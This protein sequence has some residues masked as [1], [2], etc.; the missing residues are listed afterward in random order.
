[1][2]M[3]TINS[4]AI[5]T[6][7]L[8]VF[9]SLAAAQGTTADGVMQIFEAGRGGT[10]GPILRE[11]LVFCPTTFAGGFSV[12]CFASAG[13]VR[14]VV[15]ND[16][17]TTENV[18]PFYIVGNSGD[19]VNPW[20]SY[21]SIAEITCRLPNGVIN[22]VQVI[23]SCDLI[24]PSPMAD[25]A[26][27]ATTPEP[28]S[29]P[30]MVPNPFPT[31]PSRPM[32][33]VTPKPLTEPLILP[34]L[35]APTPTPVVDF[36]LAAVP[37]PVNVAA[38]PITVP[39]VS[40]APAQ[41]DAP[42][43]DRANCVIIKATDYI[44]PMTEGWVKEKDCV[45]FRKN[46]ASSMEADAGT[47]I[48]SYLFVSPST[49]KFAVTLD[50]TTSG[51]AHNSVYLQIAGGFELWR[52]MQMTTASGFVKAFSDTAG[53][54]IAAYSVD[55]APHTFVTAVPLRSGN[56]NIIVVGARSTRV[57]V[58]RVIMW[59]CEGTNCDA[60]SAEWKKMRNTCSS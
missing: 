45:T 49:S 6:T 12:K 26:M 3:A 34:M 39:I 28:V 32:A 47:S 25:M 13:P 42:V 33:T 35:S 50:T 22:T 1:M 10:A 2:N 27:M 24:T 29:V 46:G 31:P 40:S 20:S 38:A 60:S 5:A 43:Q 58:H 23:F 11:G 53:R 18:T 56:E 36:T 59:P 44:P 19:F 7:L 30:D 52:D 57:S 54:S 51:E 41:M 4:V 15:N 55:E 16:T 9:A 17:L 8:L 37:T 21:P 48:L 14:F